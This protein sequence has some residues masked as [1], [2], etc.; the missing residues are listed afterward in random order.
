MNEWKG[1]LV[2]VF[3][4]VAVNKPVNGLRVMEGQD[5]FLGSTDTI[6]L[7]NARFHYD[8][9]ER[10]RALL[11]GIANA[12][13]WTE[14]TVVEA[15]ETMPDHAVD[16]RYSLKNCPV[17]TVSPVFFCAAEKL[18][19]TSAELLMVHSSRSTQRILAYG[20]VGYR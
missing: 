14:G 1:R 3:G 17:S 8:P 16:I 11:E 6:W 2:C 12:H 18:E 15:P 10:R 20:D 13:A 9:D 19:V 5:V 4:N 7:R